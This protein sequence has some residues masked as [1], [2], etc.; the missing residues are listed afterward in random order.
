MGLFDT[1]VGKRRLLTVELPA[2]EK[3]N[4]GRSSQFRVQAKKV[5]NSLVLTYHLKPCHNT[6]QLETRL[7]AN[8]PII[9]PITVIKTPIK[10]CPHLLEGQTLCLWRQSSTRE[11]SRWDAAKFTV[12]FAIQA[13][14]R[15]L[16]CYEVWHSTGDWPIPDAK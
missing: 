8:Y 9:P 16:A 4:E 3:Y 14:W 5:R 10:L 12:V 11:A 15:W 2:I 7:E 1:E 6:Y 13:A